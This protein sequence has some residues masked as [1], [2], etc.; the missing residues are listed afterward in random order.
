M[1]LI[2][3][4]GVDDFAWRKGTRYGTILIDLE[5]R[6]V[7]DLL[8]ERS[9]SSFEQWLRQH[10]EVTMISRDRHGL[11]AEGAR[12]GAPTAKQVA[13]RFHLVQNLI[14]AVERELTQQRH[15]LVM[16]VRELVQRHEAETGLA[17]STD[18]PPQPGGAQPSLTQR[19]RRQQ[20]Q[21]QRAE[22]FQT[23]KGLHAQG[24]KGA[25]S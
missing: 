7:A 19:E 13:D 4:L 17:P 2:P 1:G 24:M 25:K 20:R 22:L 5:Q 14:Q 18:V 9:S 10:S 3:V 15:H 16:P 6:E 11:Y 12:C 23:V 21:Q 8:P